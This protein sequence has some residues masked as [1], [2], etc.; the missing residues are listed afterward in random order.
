[1]KK[2]AITLLIFGILFFFAFVSLAA[3]DCQPGDKAQVLWK[4][5]WYPATVKQAKGD[6]CF[7]HYDGYNNSWDE[8]VGPDRIRI[9]GQPAAAVSGINTGDAVQVK[10]KGKWYDAHVVKMS[11]NK[12]FI[13]Y[14]GYSNSWDEWVGPNRIR[15]K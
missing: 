3:A 10:W 8:W 14:D 9:A 4:G 6:Q 5:K 12:Y 15:A 7:I 1:M 13:H 11:G 2:R